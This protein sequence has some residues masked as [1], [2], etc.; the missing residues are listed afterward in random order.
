MLI[1]A[2]KLSFFLIRDTGH[3]T[4]FLFAV[5]TLPLRVV[6]T[7]IDQVF[8]NQFQIK[9][10]IFFNLTTI[11]LNILFSLLFIFF[12]FRVTSLFLGIL[13]S[14]LIL[15]PVRFLFIRKMIL[16][17][18]ELNILK[19]VLQYG[20]PFVPASIA[21]WIFSSI[22]RIMLERLVDL[23]SVGIY[24]IA[25]SFSSIMNIIANAVGQAWSPHAINEYEKD[26][27]KAKIIYLR[28]LKLLIIF[29]LLALFI[30]VSF[31][32]KLISILFPPDYISSFYPALFLMI[33]IMFQMTNQVTAI[34]ISLYKKTILFFYITWFIAIVNIILN[35]LLIPH[36]KEVGA[37]IATALSY[38]ILTLIYGL[39]SQ[40]FY[41]LP[42]NT[43]EFNI[44][45]VILVS[46]IMI[47]FL[48]DIMKIALFFIVSSIFILQKKIVLSFIK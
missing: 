18:I 5:L 46:I 34:G 44:F 36:F 42:Y 6:S 28:F 37:S 13:V 8:R 15:F 45:T 4:T 11:T 24:T 27:N 23:R 19:K 41:K 1:I 38:L 7:L 29:S 48:P 25:S 21:Y 9:K 26:R 22:D 16:L 39:V 12:D 33:G 47:S 20:V 43:K 32:K 2:N 40:K 31:G 3:I 17:S 35:Y 30:F 10:Y 14:D